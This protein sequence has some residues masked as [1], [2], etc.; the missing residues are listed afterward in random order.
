MIAITKQGKFSNTHRHAEGSLRLL[1]TRLL[2]HNRVVSSGA[3][4]GRPMHAC[5]SIVFRRT[6]QMWGLWSTY[7]WIWGMVALPYP[8]FMF[9]TNTFRVTAENEQKQSRPARRC[10]SASPMKTATQIRW[11]SRQNSSNHWREWKSLQS[12]E[13]NVICDYQI[14]AIYSSGRDSVLGWKGSVLNCPNGQNSFTGV[15]LKKLIC[16]NIRWKAK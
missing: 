13:R 16:V 6:L 11:Q 7:L 5:S 14:A 15:R 8:G 2:S 9:Q 1:T 12:F 10:L 4:A 3:T